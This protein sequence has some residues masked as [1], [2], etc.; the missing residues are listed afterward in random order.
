MEHG[1]S[2]EPSI[3]GEWSLQPV[4]NYLEM[5]LPFFIFLFAL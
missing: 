3:M 5:D 1:R 4:E 2:M